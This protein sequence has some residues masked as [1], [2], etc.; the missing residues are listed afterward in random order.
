[1]AERPASARSLQ[2]HAWLGL[3]AIGIFI[4]GLGG[5]A[6]T[7]E[8]AGAV[9]ASGTV[10]LEEGSKRVQHQEGGIV[11]EILVRDGDEVE[12]GELLV[13]LDGT[14]IAANLAVIVSQLSEAFAL[15][16]RLMAESTG[17]AEIVRPAALANWPESE[18]L[19]D[20]FAAQDR[21][22]KSRASAREGLASQLEEQ[23][24]QLEEQI[25]GLEAQRQAASE[26]LAIL[27]AEGAD[28]DKLFA[29]GLVQ[30]GRVNAI[31]RDLA[32][33]RGEEGR[34]T[35]AIAGARTAIAERRTQIAQGV[36]EFQTE[37]LQELRS[38]GL[39][40]AELL[41]QKIA[42]EDRL[43]RLEIR[44][45]L[46]GVIHESIVRTVGGVVAAGETLMMVVPQA[47]RLAVET[48]VA[49]IDIDK[50]SVGQAVAVKLTGFD[51]R[52]TPELA[53]AIRSISPDLSRDEATGAP[54]YSVKVGLPESEIARLPAGQKLV[55]GM[56]AETFMRT[57]DRTVL[58]YLVEP[59][60]AQLRRAFRED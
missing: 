36:D 16:A 3:G 55:P 35:A 11:D 52:T 2:R 9:V 6:G 14:T 42:A 4:L 58:A 15:Q 25:G 23:I 48:R 56:P 24:R 12:A 30:V 20:L 13:R 43:A 17:A 59:L 53:A 44:A 49:P 10:V 1:M 41:Q 31:K 26:E 51:A 47:S 32:R 7:T 21:L 45:P 18:P 37:V 33:L 34:I 27:T 46:E 38:V 50:L 22:R 54:F 60:A 28:I 5:W 29:E 19:D 39:Q 57:G 40:V 8:I